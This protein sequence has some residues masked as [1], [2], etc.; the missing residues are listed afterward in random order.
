M[1]ILDLLDTMEHLEHLEAKHPM[2]MMSEKLTSKFLLQVVRLKAIQKHRLELFNRFNSQEIGNYPK[3]KILI[4]N[5]FCIV[6]DL[7]PHRRRILWRWCPF[8]ERLINLLIL[9][10]QIL[11]EDVI[12]KIKLSF[13]LIVSNKNVVITCWFL[14]FLLFQLYWTP[15]D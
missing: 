13:N 6:L 15:G 14:T 8:Q 3:N 11:Y 2:K 1:T 12:Q 5:L 7:L 4:P 10:D 9:G